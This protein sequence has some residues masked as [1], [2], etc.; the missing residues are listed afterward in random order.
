M[1]IPKWVIW[2]CMPYNRHRHRHF[3]LDMTI[4]ANI[5]IW[6]ASMHF[7][8]RLISNL[9]LLLMMNLRWST[10][11]SKIIL[12]IHF[13]TII[14]KLE[15]FFN[16]LTFFFFDGTTRVWTQFR[17]SEWCESRRMTEGARETEK[18]LY[19]RTD[20]YFFLS[21]FTFSCVRGQNY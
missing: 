18:G 16:H 8:T 19:R 11:A 2:R 17:P 10:T 5:C 4:I 13:F 14:N 9:W 1:Q 15:I 6:N 3:I 7:L 20:Q 12:F 21:F